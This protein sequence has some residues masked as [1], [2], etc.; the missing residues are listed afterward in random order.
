[1]LPTVD[2]S[3]TVVLLRASLKQA[4]SRYHVATLEG[5]P[6]FEFSHVRAQWESVLLTDVV[7]ANMKP[8]D[9]IL[10]TLAI[11]QVL[12]FCSVA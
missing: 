7:P 2:N 8:A 5:T 12:L 11:L 4:Q 9:T 6:T 1:M 10:D 3:K